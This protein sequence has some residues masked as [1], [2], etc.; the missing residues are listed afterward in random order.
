MAFFIFVTEEG[1]AIFFLVASFSLVSARPIKDS[2][3]CYGATVTNKDEI[4]GF[5]DFFLLEVS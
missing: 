4:N 3:T 1:D 5:C 2:R